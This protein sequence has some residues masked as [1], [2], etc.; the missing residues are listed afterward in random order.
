MDAKW[1]LECGLEF[2]PSDPR[3]ACCSRSCASSR[4]HRAKIDR[5][6]KA[7]CMQCAGDFRPTRRD[8]VFCSETCSRHHRGPDSSDQL[9][10]ARDCD[11]PVRARDMCAM[12]WRRWARETGREQ[13]PAWTEERR[14]AWHER[15]AQK[16]SATS[17]RFTSLE[18]FERDGW[19]CGICAGPV[20]PG[21]LYPDAESP[22]LDHIQPLSQ[23]GT[24]TRDNVQCS[25]LRC[26]VRKG[27]QAS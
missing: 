19:V 11:R 5:A 25:H 22:S 16:V 21:R 9:C 14:A 20:D 10:G 17:E 2:T 8:Q 3:V 18:I 13:G 7:Q 26:N 12:H 24:H 27:A 23:S 4:S 6:L 1:C 15:R